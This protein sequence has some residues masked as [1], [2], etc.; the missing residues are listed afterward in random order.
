MNGYI[1]DLQ[2]KVDTCEH[3]TSKL[4]KEIREMELEKDRLEVWCRNVNKT[5]TSDLSIMLIAKYKQDID[6]INKK[7]KERNNELTKIE[8]IKNDYLK[9]INATSKYIK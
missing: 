6:N 7:I 9:L 3:N 8:N 4:Y 2:F 5:L 1:D